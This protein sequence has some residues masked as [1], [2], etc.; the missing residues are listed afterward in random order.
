[1]E[2]IGTIFLVKRILFI[3][4]HKYEK[5]QLGCFYLVSNIEATAE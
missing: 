4:R 1:M 3:F 5:C 2:Q